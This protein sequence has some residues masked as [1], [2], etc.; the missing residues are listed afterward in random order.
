MVSMVMTCIQDAFEA[1][2]IWIN[3]NYY[4]D[5]KENAE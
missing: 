4:C 1:K 3:R 2:N 5:L